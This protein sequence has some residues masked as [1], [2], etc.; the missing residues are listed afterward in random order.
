MKA[1]L[2]FHMCEHSLLL[3][4]FT[5]LCRTSACFCWHLQDLSEATLITIQI[6]LHPNDI[7]IIL[8]NLGHSTSE[9]N[10]S[11]SI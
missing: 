8:K 4:S 5:L 6:T 10:T 3:H 9:L 11:I 7:C 1:H 2:H